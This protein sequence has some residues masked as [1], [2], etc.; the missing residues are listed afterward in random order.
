MSETNTKKTRRT[1]CDWLDVKTIDAK[2]PAEKPIKLLDGDGLYLLVNPNGSKWWRLKYRFAGREK[3]ISLGVYP[4]VSLAQAR[5]RKVAAKRQVADGMDPSAER[6]RA[7]VA[8]NQTFEMVYLEWL[9]Q[10][11]KVLAEITVGKIKAIIESK[12]LPRL[13]SR[14]VG[15]I[16]PP[17]IL[18][19]LR[20]I[21]ADGIHETAHR[22]KQMISQIMRYAV[23][24]GRATRDP[25]FDLRGAL[26]P[27]TTKNHASITDPTRVGQLLQAIDGYVG[28]PTTAAAL[29][30]AALTFV[31]PGELR[32]AEWREINLDAAEWRIAAGR[33]KMKTEHVV[34]LSL[35]AVSVFRDLEPLTG[36]GKYV[37]PSLLGGHRPMSENTV[38]TAL[39]R[40]GYTNEEMT[41]HGFR[42]MASTLLN[43]QGFH[44]DVIELQLAHKERNKV[45][46]A[47]NK[48]ERLAERRIMMQ[49][50]ADHLDGLKSGAN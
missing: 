50:W 5:K 3:G 16:G 22:A 33:M 12:V 42:S 36:G 1:G 48:A 29:R 7:K 6:Q 40:L 9:A 10:Q 23:A 27:A 25:T 19:V 13:G 28:Q 21:E 31:R 35:Q 41:G 4:A 18:E 39:R 24:T 44:P 46:A 30:L 34:P 32:G 38:N 2:K 11:R 20:K 14:P 47:Y 37:F 17:E 15:Q 43:E 26:T 45:R 49:A 8:A